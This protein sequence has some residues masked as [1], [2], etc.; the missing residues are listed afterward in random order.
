MGRKGTKKKKKSHRTCSGLTSEN[1]SCSSFWGRK[2]ERGKAPSP[3]RGCPW[4]RLSRGPQPPSPS[5]ATAAGPTRHPR[6]LPGSAL[7]DPLPLSRQA[8][9]RGGRSAEP[10]TQ[11]AA[12]D[13]HGAGERPGGGAVDVAGVADDVRGALLQAAGGADVVDAQEAAAG[14]GDAPAALTVQHRHRQARSGARRLTDNTALP[15]AAAAAA[16]QLR[17]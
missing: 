11:I 13:E 9:R 7:P 2:R 16:Q 14:E 1:G 10:L 8:P 6:A 15:A 4:R 12:S 5:S 17:H 3:P